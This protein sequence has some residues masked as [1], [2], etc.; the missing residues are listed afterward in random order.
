MPE[1]LED[2]EIEVILAKADELVSWANDIKEY[3]LQKAVSGKEWKD[4]KLVEGRSN[5]RYVNDKA[6]AEKIESA[7]YC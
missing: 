5:R 7:G 6:V 4:W 1:S 3:A 2:D